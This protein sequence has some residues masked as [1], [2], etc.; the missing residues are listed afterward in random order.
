[1]I[2]VG[3]A[4]RQLRKSQATDFPRAG[5]HLE[6]C[7]KRFN[8]VEINSSFH[9][10]HRRT[11]YERWTA[12]V[13]A[14][15]AFAVK[16]PREITHDLRLARAGAALDAFLAQ[17][18]GLGSKLGVRLLQ[19]PPRL[20]CEPR[21]PTWFTSRTEDLLIRHH[22]ARVAADP[23]V[24]PDAAEPGG[25]PGFSYFRLP[26]A[27]RIYWSAYRPEQ[28]AL[29]A[30]RLEKSKVAERWCILDKTVLGAATETRSPCAARLPDERIVC[31]VRFDGEHA[32]ASRLGFSSGCR[33]A[34]LRAIVQV[35]P[36]GG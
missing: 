23:A 25:W 34:G 10:P 31:T 30:D 14:G 6:R 8:A 33:R 19:L 16:A 13:P 18:S 35:R 20:A 5:S 17:A 22:I 12:S 27:P 36:P 32:N 26:G 24:V 7:A 2:R 28:I 21:H 11:T 3:T 1:M 15:F 4:G 29:Y 9:K